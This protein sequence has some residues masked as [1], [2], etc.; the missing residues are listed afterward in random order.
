LATAADEAGPERDVIE[1]VFADAIQPILR[2]C[3]ETAGGRFMAT[4]SVWV[5]EAPR[6]SM[7]S[8]S[9]GDG[10][11]TSSVY[12][13][14]RVRLRRTFNPSR[15]LFRAE[16]IF[17]GIAEASGFSGFQLGGAVHLDTM[18][19]RVEPS[20]GVY[21]YNVREWRGWVRL[22]TPQTHDDWL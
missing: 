21:C 9:S 6:F 20:C 15:L 8:V 3:E 1:S 2:A 22:S 11:A 13:E 5:R 14:V 18:G 16:A 10:M 7:T 17:E 12:A 19:L 4:L